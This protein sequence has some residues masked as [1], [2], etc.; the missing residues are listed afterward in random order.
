MRE[1]PRTASSLS[2]IVP[3]DAWAAVVK[4]VGK[5]ILVVVAAGVLG[6]GL[7]HLPV[8]TAVVVP[9]LV[10][11]LLL[12]VLIL[13]TS[14]DGKG[15]GLD[16][17]WLT[18]WT[19]AALVA[20]LCIGI[21][22]E[23]SPNLLQRYLGPD[24]AYYHQ[25]SAQLARSWGGDWPSPALPSGKEGFIYML[26]G[27]Y[28]LFGSFPVAGVAVNAVFSAALIPVTVDTTKRLFGAKT[29]R[30]V[31]PLLLFLPGF[32]VWTSQLLREAAVLLLLGVAINCAVRLT[33]RFSLAVV[34][35]FAGALGLLLSFRANVAVVFTAALLI[36]MV[37]ARR[38]LLPGIVTGA[39]GLSILMVLV[40][41]VGLGYSGYRLSAQADLRQ[42][43][44]IRQD[45]STSTSGF[46]TEVDVSS[47]DRAVAF[48]PKGLVHVLLGP[49]PWEARNTRQILGVLEAFCLL[50]LV[51]FLC[52]GLSRARKLL[53]RQ[54]L[55]HI[56]PAC[57]VASMLGLIIGNYGTIVRERLQIIVVLLPFFALGLD[58]WG[59]RRAAGKSEAV[60][61]ALDREPGATTTQPDATR[62]VA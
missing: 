33:D 56:L 9:T 46:A 30:W 24:A 29:A 7:V 54:L 26:A 21:V 16:H 45:L 49:F 11:S 19:L 36:G 5:T 20:H 32:L 60:T 40:L 57:A 18:R 53:G 4:P 28:K 37:I 55:V 12:C 39:A 8:M 17:R 2:L 3:S 34:T 48:L 14:A 23:A 10:G 50:A 51:P 42:V 13:R 22:V 38:H 1:L 31:P 15:G 61:A 62:A 58:E 47:T 35:A 25:L 41:A 52:V 59:T 43:N 44:V 6:S 27:L